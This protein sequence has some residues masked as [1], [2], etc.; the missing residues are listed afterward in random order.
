MIIAY[1]SVMDFMNELDKNS[2][3]KGAYKSTM[4]GRLFFLLQTHYFP[5]MNPKEVSRYIEDANILRRD[6]KDQLSATIIAASKVAAGGF[7]L[8]K[9]LGQHD[10]VLVETRQDVD[11]DKDAIV[12]SVIEFHMKAIKEMPR[13]EAINLITNQSMHAVGIKDMPKDEVEKL[14]ITRMEKMRDGS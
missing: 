9:K 5:T 1:T 2:K 11:V 7:G 6:M 14:V 12:D 4:F 3:I 13:D 10:D 8:D